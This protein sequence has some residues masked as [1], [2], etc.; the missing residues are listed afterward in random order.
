MH[1]AI[2]ALLVYGEFSG[3][4]HSIL[5]QMRALLNRAAGHRFSVLAL[6]DVP[7]ETHLGATAN[8]YAVLRAPLR[9]GQRLQRIL[10]EQ[11]M[12]PRLLQA[13]GVDLL[14][15]PGYLTPLRWHG[16]AV[17]YVHDTIA[18]S[19]PRLCTRGNALNYRLLLPPATRHATLVATPSYRLRA[20]M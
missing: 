14:Y 18:L 13:Q 10:W 7:I 20:A 8:A 1:I 11:A 2:N 4:Q 15:S 12:L 17:V 16:P 6:A 3:V 9:G 19:H 5:H